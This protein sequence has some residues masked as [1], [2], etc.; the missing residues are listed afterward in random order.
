M[1]QNKNTDGNQYCIEWSNAHRERRELETIFHLKISF[2]GF[3]WHD[4]GIVL[5]F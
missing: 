3:S 5:V 2:A 4:N 1:L